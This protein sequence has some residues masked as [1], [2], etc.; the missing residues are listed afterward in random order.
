MKETLER[1]LNEYLINNGNIITILQDIEK[2]FGYIPEDAVNWFSKRLDI[3]ASRFYGVATFYA[4]FHLK[5]KGKNVITVCRGTACHVKGSAKLLI[6]LT[7]KFGLPDGENTTA[8]G[9]FTLEKV[10]CE[11]TCSMAPVVLVNGQV[12]GKMTADKLAREIKILKGKKTKKTTGND[13]S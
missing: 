4:Q 12:C 7:R 2:N 1:I 13:E 3:P 8:D 10:A 6:G 5:P 11:G 9:E